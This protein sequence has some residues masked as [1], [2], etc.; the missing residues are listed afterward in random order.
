MSD[1]RS[2]AIPARPATEAASSDWRSRAVP[3]KPAAE[4]EEHNPLQTVAANFA[5]MVPFSK[6]AAAALMAA[7]LKMQGNPMDFG[8]N[9]RQLRTAIDRDLEASNK[10]NPN[11]KWVGRGAGLVAGAAAGG[12]G[13]EAGEGAGLLGKA[14][15]LA[16]NGG[17]YSAVSRA[18]EELP[19]LTQGNYGKYAAELAKAF[20]EGSAGGLAL[21][22]L[23][24]AVGMGAGRLLRGLVKVGPAAKLLMR[25]GADDLTLG[26]M[27]GPASAVAQMEDAATSMPIVGK[28]LESQR[29]EGARSVRKAFANDALAPGMERITSKDVPSMVGSLEQ[30]FRRSYEPVA[31]SRVNAFYEGVPMKQAM[32]EAFEAAADSPDSLAT[33]EVRDA[34]R[35][36]LRNQTTVLD[37]VPVMMDEGAEAAAPV[38]S[39]AGQL[40][41]PSTTDKGAALANAA[42]DVL[43]RGASR[44]ITTTAAPP[45]GTLPAEV[46]MKIRSN[47]REKQRG[48]SDSDKAELLEGAEDIMSRTL[49][50]QLSPEASALLRANDKQYRKFKIFQKAAESTT[51]PGNAFTP[52]QYAQ[53]VRRA[54][55]PAEYARGGGGM[56]RKL[57]DAA[58]ETIES[59]IPLNGIRAPI[60]APLGYFTSPAAAIINASPG[61]KRLL[62]GQTDLQ[63]KLL[64]RLL[65]AQQDA[66]ALTS[67]TEPALGYAS[68][69][70]GQ[71]IEGD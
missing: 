42:E 39:K 11:A 37:R 69:A 38:A 15:A 41:L 13:L 36:Y 17:L 71:Y 55:D 24:K 14:A 23:G 28:F 61:A 2:R 60:L 65:R 49:E 54:T 6:D 56:P 57:A 58:R 52:S 46:L 10:E 31:E 68:N 8:E 67:S 66:K 9:Y 18:S 25:K 4:T 70:I 40:L 53:A 32:T 59:K 47:I 12:P 27:A 44:P 51:A 7:K 20:G 43:S 45:S 29:E 5:D 22:G 48:M 16:G 63:R 62:T 30:G 35:K 34:V 64:I 1:W 50:D 19:E 26:Q 21:G 3:V 33:N